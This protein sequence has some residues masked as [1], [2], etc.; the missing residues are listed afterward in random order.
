MAGVV[1]ALLLAE[2]CPGFVPV[3]VREASVRGAK[4]TS[5]SQT[6]WLEGVWQPPFT[7]GVAATVKWIAA[8][9]L[10]RSP[11]GGRERPKQHA[12]VR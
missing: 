12:L 9:P 1:V 7:A 6:V 4:L 11:T 5:A 2:R 10:L 3:L 8:V